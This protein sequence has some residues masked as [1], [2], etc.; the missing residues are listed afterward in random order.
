MTVIP[1]KKQEQ[2]LDQQEEFLTQEEEQAGAPPAEEVAAGEVDPRFRDQ[3]SEHVVVMDDVDGFKHQI[4]N[5]QYVPI[6]K[7][8]WKQFK[9][10]ADCN[11]FVILFVEVQETKPMIYG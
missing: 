10:L 5:D 1:L 9:E 4:V 6:A 3:D 7:A 8:L 2:D 11:P